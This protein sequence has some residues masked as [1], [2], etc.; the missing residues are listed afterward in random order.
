MLQDAT[1]TRRYD[2]ARFPPA[3]LAGGAPGRASRF[4]IRVG[5]AAEE[6]TP[7]SGRYTLKAGERFLLECAGGGGYG[8]PAERDAAALATDIAEGRVSA[9]AA[10]TNGQK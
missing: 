8:D 9:D 6:E 3:G 10:Y 7:A 4:V 5:T 1:I 2:R